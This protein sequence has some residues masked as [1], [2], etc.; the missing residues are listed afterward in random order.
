MRKASSSLNS[1]FLS[2]LQLSDFE[3]R[4]DPLKVESREKPSCSP[5]QTCRSFPPQLRPNPF[6]PRPVLIQPF[7]TSFAN[8]APGARKRTPLGR[9]SM[10]TTTQPLYHI[11]FLFPSH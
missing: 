6:S 7:C 9:A 11:C 4:A 1:L 8:E 5:R 2:S 3:G 10:P